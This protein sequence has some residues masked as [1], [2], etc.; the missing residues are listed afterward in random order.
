[1]PQHL[2]TGNTGNERK[3]HTFKTNNTNSPVAHYSM[4]C[5]ICF[6]SPYMV[7]GNT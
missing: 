7:T 5:V 1:M 2:K 3:A 4:G 6:A